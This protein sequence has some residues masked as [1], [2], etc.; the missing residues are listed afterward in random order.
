MHSKDFHIIA[1][2]LGNTNSLLKK[3]NDSG[4]D[5]SLPTLFIAECVLVYMSDVYTNNLLRCITQRFQSVCFISCDMVIHYTKNI[6]RDPAQHLS[7]NYKYSLPC[8]KNYCI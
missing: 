4:I 2:D 6:L 3:L 5:Q 1:A 8:F 7:H